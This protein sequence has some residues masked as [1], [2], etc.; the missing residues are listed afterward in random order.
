MTEG[1]VFYDPNFPFHDG[2]IGK[3]LFVLLNDGQDGSYL[4]VLSTTK[5]KKMSGIAGCHATDFPPNYHFP[6][7]TDFPENSWLLIDNIYEF[8]CFALMQKIKVGA[9]VSKAPVSSTSLVDVLD[10]TVEG[11]GISSRHRERLQTFR[12]SLQ[13]IISRT[14]QD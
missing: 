5:Q 7:G 10:C 12:D 11:D 2:E 8:D 4:T 1:S 3:K 6:A 9:I 13:T 14:P